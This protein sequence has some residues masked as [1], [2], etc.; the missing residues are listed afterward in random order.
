[1][2]RREARTAVFTL[3]FQADFRREEPLSQVLQI[4]QDAQD[5]PQEYNEYIRSVYYG[6]WEKLPELD[7]AISQ[8]AKG[9][10]LSRLSRVSLALLRLAV[11]E[12]LYVA[13][14]PFHVAINEALELAK[15]YDE[16]KSVP[17]LN[18]VLNAIADAKGLKETQQKGGEE[19]K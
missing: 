17:F 13:D 14:V 10:K 16:E 19:A 9:W 11:Y 8:N 2:T 15:V 4:A 7:E 12:M 5:E 18:G 3:I 6:V 1:M